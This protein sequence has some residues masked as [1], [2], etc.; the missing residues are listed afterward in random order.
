MDRP[1]G[2]SQ[3]ARSCVKS[4]EQSWLKVGEVPE[5]S[6][7]YDWRNNVKSL[8]SDVRGKCSNEK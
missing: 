3:A 8:S 7:K 1:K 5:E 6:T 2:S 4:V